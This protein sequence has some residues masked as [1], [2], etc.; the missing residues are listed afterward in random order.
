MQSAPPCLRELAVIAAP[1]I[2]SS[3]CQA[4]AA[5]TISNE[6]GAGTLS[7]NRE[8]RPGHRD[9][10]FVGG[11]FGHLGIVLN[12]NN[13]GA[14]PCQPEGCATSAGSAF[15]ALMARRTALL[16]SLVDSDRS[17]LPP[18]RNCAREC[19]VQD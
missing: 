9:P 16:D 17:P 6:R 11:R 19:C 2:G 5:A 15:Q 18:V 13:A 1:P 3:Q 7:S 12:R 14:Q 8:R 4:W 10:G